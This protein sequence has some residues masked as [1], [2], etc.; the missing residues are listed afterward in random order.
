MTQVR[1]IVEGVAREG[2]PHF[3][4][5]ESAGGPTS[6]GRCKRCGAQKEFFN[7]VPENQGRNVGVLEL[8]EMPE[9]EFDAEQSS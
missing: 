7:S 1:D 8:P 2:C 6:R 5:I 4:V 9:V 3:W